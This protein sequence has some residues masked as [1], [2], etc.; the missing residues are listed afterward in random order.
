M[1]F[2]I[3]AVNAKY[4]HSNLAVYSLREFAAKNK[5]SS[6][7]IVEY[8]INQEYK[9]ILSSLFSHN[10]THIAFSCYIWNI[11]IINKLVVD[12]NKILPDVPIWLGGPEVSYS[13]KETVKRLPMIRGVMIG[14][15]EVTFSELVD[16]YNGNTQGDLEDIAGLYLSEQVGFSKSRSPISLDA[17][18]FIYDDLN[19]FEHRILYYESSRGCP[20]RCSYCLSS[21]DKSLRFRSMD[22]VKSELDF[23]LAN[24]VRQVKFIDRTFN[25]SSARAIEIWEYIHEHDNGV[26]NFHFEIAADILTE[27]EFEILSK[28]RKGQVQLEIGVQTTNPKTIEAINRK[29]DF[30]KVSIA[31]KRLLMNQNIHLHL[32]LIAGLPYEDYESFAHSFNDVYNLEPDELQLGFLKLL[33]GTQISRDQDKYNIKAS[34]FAPYEVLSTDWLSYES[35]LRLKE[36]EEVLD[37]FY[38]S[39]QFSCTLKYLQSLFDTSFEFYENLATFF[40]ENYT[41]SSSRVP[42]FGLLHDFAMKIDPCRMSLYKEALAYDFYLRDNQKSRPSFFREMIKTPEFNNKIKA[43]LTFEE[44]SSN[45]NHH[46]EPFYYKVW[47]GS[48]TQESSPVVIFFDYTNRDIITNN[49]YTKVLKY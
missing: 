45:R 20:F 7:N 49:C 31:T 13:P 42:R 43:T 8:T 17:L 35:L 47:E 28:L 46:I 2:L 32:D 23:F 34:S 16:F 9:D 6:L 36:C 12:I 22:M 19:N 11:E 15:G 25:A 24:N 21:I 39:K 41:Y 14:E 5:D 29:M 33:S 26:T 37:L 3:V 27:A 38:N 40:K 1:N 4:I 30:S 18:P 44:Q 48:M 10:Q